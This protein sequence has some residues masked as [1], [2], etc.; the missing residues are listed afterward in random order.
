MVDGN[1]RS[2]TLPDKPKTPT[3]EQAK[4][5]LLPRQRS[6]SCHRS[7][8]ITQIIW[9]LYTKKNRFRCSTTG[10]TA[11]LTGNVRLLHLILSNRRT[12]L[13]FLPLTDHRFPA[14]SL[15]TRLE[16]RLLQLT[17]RHK[18]PPP[19]LVSWKPFKTKQLFPWQRG[20]Q[21]SLGNQKQ[22][23]GTVLMRLKAHNTPIERISFPFWSQSRSGRPQK[24]KLQTEKSTVTGQRAKP[25]K[26][27]PS[28][29]F[30][31]TTQDCAMLYNV[32]NFVRVHQLNYGKADALK[33]IDQLQWIP[34]TD[35]LLLGCGLDGML[36]IWNSELKLV[37]ELNLKKMKDNYLKKFCPMVIPGNIT[38]EGDLCDQGDS[39]RVEIE[40]VIRSM[41]SNGQGSRFVKTA[42][43][44]GKLLLLHCVDNSLVVVSSDAWQIC[45]VLV[46]TNLFITHFDVLGH[47]EQSSAAGHELVVVVKT[48]DSDLCLMN[49]EDGTRRCIVRGPEN[50]CYKFLPSRNGKM[51]ANVLKSGQVLLHNLEFHSCALKANKLQHLATGKTHPR[52][53]KTATASRAAV[54]CNLVSQSS[55][56]SLYNSSSGM[57]TSAQAVTTGQSTSV[58]R[59]ESKLKTDR[60]LE[61]IHD[62]VCALLFYV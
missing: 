17:H 53:L 20:N 26:A 25:S 50:K 9:P 58:F 41:T 34:K 33:R 56:G 12:L 10:S 48:V 52:P 60:R 5:Q 11:N 30:L 19:P 54:N 40:R 4:A 57:T 2:V 18:P 49:L 13:L 46:F 55:G 39:S 62:K 14:E 22:H 24:P 15:F 7:P 61:D 45:K 44:A 6:F 36:Q 32:R 38:D 47:V 28:M 21:L 1:Q 37:R 59:K 31:V 42:R 29:L 35:A 27:E 3:T 51:L 16:N 8:V 43:F 23:T